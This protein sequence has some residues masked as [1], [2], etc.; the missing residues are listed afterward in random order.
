V[1]KFNTPQE[2]L[3]GLQNNPDAIVI[4]RLDEAEELKGLDLQQVAEHHDIF[5]TPITVLYVY[6][7][8]H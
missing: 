7:A 4:T 5:E 1:K 6:K 8:Q 2:L 3:Q